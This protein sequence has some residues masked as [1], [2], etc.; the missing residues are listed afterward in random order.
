MDNKCMKRCTTSLIIEEM[1][2]KNH[3]EI[4]SYPLGWLLSNKNK[5]KTQKITNYGEELKKLEYLGTVGENIK[6]WKCF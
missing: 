2:V 6:W 4:T 3:S 5:N 1:Q